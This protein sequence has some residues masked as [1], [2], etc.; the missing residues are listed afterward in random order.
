[1]FE[2][3]KEGPKKQRSFSVRDD[4]Y[5]ALKALDSQ[6]GRKNVSGRVQEAIDDYLERQ[7]GKDWATYWLPGAVRA[8][9][10]RVAAFRT[11]VA[12]EEQVA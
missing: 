1:M 3:Q 12:E 11:I 9:R 2:I 6:Q 10:E 5:L 7:C 8:M 4:Q